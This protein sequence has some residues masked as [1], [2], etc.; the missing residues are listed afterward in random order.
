MVFGGKFRTLFQFTKHCFHSKMKSLEKPVSKKY[1]EYCNFI[2]EDKVQKE[3]FIVDDSYFKRSLE[4]SVTIDYIA[5]MANV[6]KATVSRVINN[7]AEGVGKETRARVQQVIEEYGYKPNLLARGIATSHTKIIGL[8]I[9]DI[10]NP[11]FPAMI[12]AIENYTSKHGYTV[13]LCDTDSSKEKEKQCISMLIANRVDGII[14]DTVLEEQQSISYDFSKYGIPCVL[15]DRKNKG[16]NYGAGIFVDNEYAFYIAA[17]LLILHGNERIAFIQGPTDLSTTRERLDGYFSALKQ[18]G[19]KKVP[20]LVIPGSFTY[21]SGYNA[22]IQL[23]EKEVPFTAVLASN[24]IMAFGALKAL[25]DIGRKVPDEVEVIGFDNVQFSEIVDPPLTTLDQ[26]LYDMGNK[27][28]EAII[29]LIEGRRLS[30]VNIRMEAK[31]VMRKSTRAEVRDR[32]KEK[33]L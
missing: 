31:L 11:F 18:Y 4:M 16:L 2:G 25:R 32:R 13:I 19:L 24:D 5:R 9:P 26:P 30:E 22:I 8:V 21:E 17:E 12:K 33:N 15:I 7:K 29:S 3:R 6:S 14:L 20:E 28:A 10:T 1:D 23:Y 27:A